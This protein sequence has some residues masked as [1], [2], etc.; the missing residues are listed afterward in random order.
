MNK[1]I[2]D[3]FNFVERLVWC[4]VTGAFLLIAGIAFVIAW[5]IDPEYSK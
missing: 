4:V 2:V 3:R 1:E 5:V